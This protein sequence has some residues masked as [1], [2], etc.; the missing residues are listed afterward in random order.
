MISKSLKWFL[1]VTLPVDFHP[2]KNVTKAFQVKN[3]CYVIVS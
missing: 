2:A 3:E 1:S